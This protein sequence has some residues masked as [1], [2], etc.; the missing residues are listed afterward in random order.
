MMQNENGFPKDFL[1]GGAVSANQCEGAWRC[2]GKG[3]SIADIEELPDCYNRCSVTGFQHSAQEAAKAAIDKQ[4]NYPRRRGIDFYHTYR[5]DIALLKEM[6]FTC[7]RTSFQWTRIFPNGD[8]EKPNEAGLRFYDELLDELIRNGIEPVMTI[9]H[10]EMPLQL[11]I[12]YGGWASRKV[13]ECFTHY[14]RIL[15]KRYHKKVKYWIVFNQ[16]NSMGGWGEFA[17]LGLLK[18]AHADMTVAKYQA[19]HHQFVASAMAKQMASEIDSRL[20]IG[21]MLGDDHA[22]PASCRPKD[23]LSSM[24]YMQMHTYF[25]SDT[26]LRGCYPGYACR[27]F[28][29]QGIQLDWLP[30]ELQL[31][32]DYKP[33]FLALSYY[34]TK[35]KKADQAQ[36]QDNPYL[37]TSVWGWSTDPI[38]LRIALHDYWDRYQIPMFIA[39]NGLGAVDEVVDECIHDP[40]RTA[41]LQAHLQQ[42]QEAL[43]DGVKVFGYAAWSPIDMVSASQGEMSKRYGFVYVDQDDR[44]KGTK[45]R[46]RKDSFYWY[47]RVIAS[48]GS[49]LKAE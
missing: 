33:D 22:Y 36:L 23:V 46:L 26:L 4:K 11:A 3:V 7:F 17:S 10:Y 49:D 27:F 15:L 25:Y 5:E 24:Q 32:R 48:N 37:K 1:W 16:L 47:Q 21:L 13:L 29:E 43:R 39:E 34:R 12:K 28:K 35:I 30:Q 19:I 6:G 38:G 45:K 44:G 20:Q 9:S 2:D 41:Y 8:E 42:L 18:D 31:L 14:C 40:Y